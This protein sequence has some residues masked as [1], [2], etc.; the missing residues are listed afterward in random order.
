MKYAFAVLLLLILV[1]TPVYG[2]SLS[3]RTG[4]VNRF[5]VE[6]GGHSFE[7]ELVSNFDIERHQ[8]I[9]QEKRLTIFVNS[10][11]ENNLGELIIPKEV[12]SGNFTFYIN[13]IP[14][15][16]KIQSNDKISFITL[17]FTGKGTN[18][19]DIISTNTID[20]D[21]LVLDIDDTTSEG[22]G[23]L[24]ATAAF[25]SELVP[26]IQQLR[27]IRDTKLMQTTYGHVFLQ[28]FNQLYYSFSPPIA[29]YER[30]NFMFKEIV[31]LFLTPLLSSLLLLNYANTDVQFLIIG[32]GIIAM[33]VALY[34]VAPLFLL[35]KVKQKFT[36][37]SCND[38]VPKITIS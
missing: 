14:R 35:Y 31:K 7:I 29:D 6:S 3:D 25:G 11:L 8:F 32:I 20:N 27:E 34:F 26:Q 15:E 21:V 23:C 16:Q 1:V 4:L 5:D 24:I 12:L 36:T 33:N 2:Q 17:N 13:D 10:G 22:G 30:E 18:K 19:I 28:H 37:K 9:Q 38:V